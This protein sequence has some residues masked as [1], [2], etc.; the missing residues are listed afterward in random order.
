[1]PSEPLPPVRPRPRRAVAQPEAEPLTNGTNA[2]DYSTPEPLRRLTR[3]IEELHAAAKAMA[4]P[5]IRVEW[6]PGH[7]PETEDA[8][9][10]ALKAHVSTFLSD[11]EGAASGP[12]TWPLSE[13][14]A[15]PEPHAFLVGNLIRPGTTVM[16][17]GPPGAAKSWASRQL[18]LA[19]GAGVP[20][21]LERY[22][23]TRPLKVLV[24]DEDNGPNEEWRRDETLLA[25]LDLTRDQASAVRRVSL[26][27]VRLDEEP[28]QRW[29]RG[30][31][32]LHD[33]DL[34]I[35]DPI[36]EMYAGKELRDDVA[37][38]AVL[39]FLKRLKVDFP[40]LATV[41]VHHTRKR[42]PKTAAGS[43][44]LEDVR[45]QWGQ[46]PDVVVMLSPLGERRA[47][48]EVHKRVPYSSLI[49]E[50]VAEGQPDE[51][52]LRMVADETVMKSKAMANDGAVIDAIREGM[53]TF[54]D[55]VTATG[56]AKSTVN[57]VLN[58]LQK[59][60]VITKSGTVYTAQDDD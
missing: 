36:S 31:V 8:E 53:T 56:L 34:L 2:V 14:S 18:A 49:L 5:P 9:K 11:Y 38:R 29:I 39:H 40:Q 27:G 55:V 33:L 35:L 12:V 23:I 52:S 46:T 26:E 4:L 47:K 1:M 16:M 15:P 20:L 28:W 22:E 51:G 3:S 43:T 58:R 45:G 10:R 17:A 44:S 32:R 21:F 24:V 7:E 42:D 57:R 50:Q 60:G 19:C 13:I 25:H 48:W 30:Q 6:E 37:F 59:A 54:P 41:L